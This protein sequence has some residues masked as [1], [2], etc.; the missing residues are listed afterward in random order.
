MVYNCIIYI[1][2]ICISLSPFQGRN[3]YNPIVSYTWSA[4]TLFLQLLPAEQT[5]PS[6]FVNWC[7]PLS[8]A[9]SPALISSQYNSSGMV[10]VLSIWTSARVQESWTWGRCFGY[11]RHVSKQPSRIRLPGMSR[12]VRDVKRCQEM[13]R[14]VKRCQEMSRVIIGNHQNPRTNE[15]ARNRSHHDHHVRWGSVWNG[16]ASRQL[17]FCSNVGAFES[18]IPGKLMQSKCMNYTIVKRDTSGQLHFF[19]GRI[20]QDLNS[21]ERNKQGHHLK[22]S[23]DVD[24]GPH[25]FSGDSKNQ[26][27]LCRHLVCWSFS[28]CSI[29]STHADKPASQLRLCKV[30]R[31]PIS[32]SHHNLPY[33]P[34][35][36]TKVV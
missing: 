24:R 2:I 15:A 29:A 11:L 14:D 9:R 10:V 35:A 12:D 8:L 4:S 31:L 1:Y 5:R 33:I 32:N 6:A 30:V 26:V 21:V 25:D 34:S 19:F 7:W 13:S 3:T 16:Q 28:W 18:D 23:P 22:I 17:C 27:A 36:W 20:L